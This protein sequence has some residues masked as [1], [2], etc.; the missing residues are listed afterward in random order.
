[1]LESVNVLRPKSAKNHIKNHIKNLID[2]QPSKDEP[3]ENN[4]DS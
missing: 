1:M 2:F 4:G 3:E